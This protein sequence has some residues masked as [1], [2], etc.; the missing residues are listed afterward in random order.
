MRCQGKDPATLCLFKDMLLQLEL[1]E[2]TFG[3]FPELCF[4]VTS[5]IIF[6]LMGGILLKQLSLQ[7]NVKCAY[8]CHSTHCLL[9]KY[10]VVFINFILKNLSFNLD[11]S[12]V[13]S[14]VSDCVSPGKLYI[15]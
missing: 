11:V 3:L 14:S 4:P 8:V 10:F 15:M 13:E 2:V 6:V 1:V 9:I 5:V 12:E 7:E